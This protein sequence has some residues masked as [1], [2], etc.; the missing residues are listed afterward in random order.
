MKSLVSMAHLLECIVFLACLAF[1]PNGLAEMSADEM[2]E[3]NFYVTKTKTLV[4]EEKMIL[5]TDQGQQRVRDISTQSK[6][7]ADGRNLN[8]VVRFNSPA[9]VQGTTF[10]QIQNEDRDDDMWIYLPALKKVRRLVSNNK[11]DS[12]VGSDFS[13]GDILT[14]RPSLFTHVLK[15]VET[16]EGAEC[17]RVESVPREESMAG[18]IGY[19]HKTTWLRKDNLLEVQIHYF[20][21]AGVL[22]KT[23]TTGEHKLL[24]SNPPR[25]IAMNRKMVNHETGHKTSILISKT[26]T[27]EPV[28]DE[29]FTSRAIEP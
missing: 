8:L 28:K 19:A 22:L 9:D 1:A 26:D 24:Q 27:E 2:M 23:Q 4:S 7:Q 12:F 29:A 15:G 16:V 5:E 6:L 17:F 13:Y 20:D 10:L 18:D 25:W 3:K 21:E 11:R 14:L